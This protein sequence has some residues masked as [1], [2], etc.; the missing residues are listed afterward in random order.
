M[1]ESLQL[2]TLLKIRPQNSLMQWFL[3]QLTQ[4]RNILQPKTPNLLYE[5]TLAVP[6]P[7]SEISSFVMCCSNQTSNITMAFIYFPLI[8]KEVTIEFQ[9]SI[10]NYCQAKNYY[11]KDGLQY[12]ENECL[13]YSLKFCHLKSDIKEDWYFHQQCFNV[14]AQMTFYKSISKD[15][16]ANIMT[17]LFSIIRRILDA[18]FRQMNQFLI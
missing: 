6:Q 10:I 8:L 11:N 13:K 17:L 16:L 2:I 14:L 3:K 4:I 9:R 7:E 5:W 12:Y 1:L 18:I 15:L